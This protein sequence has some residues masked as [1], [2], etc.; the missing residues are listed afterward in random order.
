[1]SALLT[2][3]IRYRDALADHDSCCPCKDLVVG[4]RSTKQLHAV[5][6]VTVQRRLSTKLEMTLP[7]GQH[8]LVLL[9]ICTTYTGC[10]QEFTEGLE[11]L[12]IAEAAESDDDDDDD[13]SD[14]AD[15][16]EED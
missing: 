9:L 3:S 12:K 7:K 10:D 8:D 16:M 4:E 1:M 14:G 15:G 2:C 13:D 6:K 11:G 5:K